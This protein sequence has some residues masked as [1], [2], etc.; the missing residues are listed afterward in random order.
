MEMYRTNLSCLDIL[1]VE[2][3]GIGW[4][5]NNLVREYY[6]TVKRNESK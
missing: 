4:N 1:K 5:V 2:I 3:N 6:T